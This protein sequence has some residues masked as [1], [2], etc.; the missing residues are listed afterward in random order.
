[1]S[2]NNYNNELNKILFK[3]RKTLSVPSGNESNEV[4]AGTALKNLTDL[5]FTL[6]KGGFD[7]L[8][9]AS[10]E[11]IQDWYYNT[12]KI[13]QE[14]V[15]ADHKY[16]PFYPNFPQDVMNKTDYE[17][18]ID[19]LTHYW[20]AAIE[21]VFGEREND[22]WSPSGINEKQSVKS[23]EEHP[24][25]VLSTIDGRDEKAVND[26]AVEV[27]QNLLK[28]KQTPSKDDMQNIIN[29]FMKNI[30]NWTIYVNECENRDTLSYMQKQFKKI[31]ILRICHH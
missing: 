12:T 23:L 11:D 9:T 24:L 1:M 14:A 5:G 25:K 15:G 8:S 21:D 6:D 27:F 30:P 20:S 16:I 3:S 31:K 13:L 2:K 26:L 7:L 28:S 22:A 10:T 17:L 18:L 29:P 19:Q 4:L